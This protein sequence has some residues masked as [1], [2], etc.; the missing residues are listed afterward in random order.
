[1]FVFLIV[2]LC[3]AGGLEYISL[4]SGTSSVETS[5]TLSDQR[6]EPGREVELITSVRNTSWMPIS[7]YS[8]QTS[9]PMLTEFPQDASVSR[10][11]HSK[12]LT[13]IYRLW[14]R[15]RIVRRV[16]FRIEKRGVHSVIGKQVQ[17]GDFFGLQ[18]S[19]DYLAQRREVLVYPRRL[20]NSRLLEAL[21]SYFGEI[22]ARRWLI[23]DPI[24]HIG[25]REYTGNEA[26][27][28]ISWSQTA[29]RGELMV[30]EFDY[31]RSMNCCVLFCLD[32]L[33]Y[34]ESELLDLCCSAVRTICEELAAKGVD[35]QLY[36][37]A[38][39]IGYPAGTYRKCVAAQGKMTDALDLLARATTECMFPAEKMAAECL[40]RDGD[41]SAFL[42][43]APRA[44]ES[45]EEALALLNRSGA[46]GAMLITGDALE[47]GAI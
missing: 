35:V 28:T 46:A 34:D 20:E 26:M 1:M 17:H 23:R 13:D 37:N 2:L 24:I 11:L 44:N 16:P 18:T 25:V 4:R 21:G 36:T 5:Y 6:I 14:S 30:R 43:L 10:E 19:S 39:L 9:F 29:R 27:R 8:V 47:G 32:G 22:S 31:T 41:N 42:L 3:I 38:A 7:Y 15:Q 45:T 12:V 40:E 33:R